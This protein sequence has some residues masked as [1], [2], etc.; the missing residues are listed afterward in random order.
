MFI[1]KDYFSHYTLILPEINDVKTIKIEVVGMREKTYNLILRVFTDR[2]KIQ[3][4]I[5][6]AG[7]K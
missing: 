6:Y 1:T 2:N 7:K 3:D 4:K 5:N